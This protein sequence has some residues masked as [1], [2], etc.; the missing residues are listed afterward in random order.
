MPFMIL[1]C[2]IL[3]SF[4]FSYHKER[5]NTGGNNHSHGYRQQERGSALRRKQ[6]DRAAVFEREHNAA[7]VAG[8]AQL[9]ERAAS[10]LSEWTSSSMLLSE[11]AYS[12]LDEQHT[13]IG[14]ITRKIATK[15]SFVFI[16]N[17]PQP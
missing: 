3:R 17:L 9:V 8:I 6:H 1:F 2:F 12:V 4:L 15:P 10:R 11:K 7:A 13:A 14:S 5:C 16:R